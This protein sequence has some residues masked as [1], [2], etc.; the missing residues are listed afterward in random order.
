MCVLHM[1]VFLKGD[2]NATTQTKTEFIDNDETIDL[3][4]FEY[5]DVLDPFY[6]TQHLLRTYNFDH[7]RVSKHKSSNNEGS[8]L[9]EICKS[10]NLIILN[11]R[12]GKDKGN[13]NFTFRNLSIIDY[14]I[15]SAH[16]FKYVNDFEIIQLDCLYSDEHSLLST[17]M[18][19]SKICN[20]LTNK[21]G[22]GKQQRRPQWRSDKQSEFCP[23]LI[24]INFLH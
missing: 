10:N 21:S 13:G 4:Y 19:F 22:H 8:W 18:E 5:D 20:K 9:L 7:T 3:E 14:S 24:K 2:F 16:A 15:A 23:T 17:V 11:G 1:Y 12:C 6:N